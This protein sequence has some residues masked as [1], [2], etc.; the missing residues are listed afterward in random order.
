MSFNVNIGETVNLRAKHTDGDGSFSLNYAT[1][2][3]TTREIPLLNVY[4]AD[5]ARLS[6]LKNNSTERDKYIKQWLPDVNTEYDYAMAWCD[7][8]GL[9]YRIT[10]KSI[11]GEGSYKTLESV[12]LNTSEIIEI[13]CY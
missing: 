8:H 6:L 1:D 4:A 13:P 11:N 9:L 3:I 10:S 12:N 2:N 7:P 5:A